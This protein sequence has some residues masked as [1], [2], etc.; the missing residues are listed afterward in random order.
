MS[1]ELFA[2]RPELSPFYFVNAVTKVIIVF[3]KLSGSLDELL[4]ILLFGRNV[5]GLLN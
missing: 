3:L 4:V 1:V 5:F 2:P